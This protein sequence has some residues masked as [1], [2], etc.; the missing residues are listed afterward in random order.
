MP[1]YEYIAENVDKSCEE[2]YNVLEVKQSI[3]DDTLTEC[4]HCGQP[5]RKLISSVG[6]SITK[7]KEMN[8]FNDVKYAKYWRDSNGVRHKVT[9]QDGRSQSPTISNRNVATEAEIK[10]RK[11]VDA[12]KDKK[13]RN[14]KSYRKYVKSIKKK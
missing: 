14:Q 2:C 11:Q 7:G 9:P 5:I 6:G 10:V 4:L 13:K 12:A 3:L 8:Q 1:F